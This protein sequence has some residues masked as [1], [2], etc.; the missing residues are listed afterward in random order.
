MQDIHRRTKFPMHIQEDVGQ[1]GQ[2]GRTDQLI[3]EHGFVWKG[4]RETGMQITG[5]DG[6]K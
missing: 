6:V 1:R 4:V 3:G 5:V 2:D